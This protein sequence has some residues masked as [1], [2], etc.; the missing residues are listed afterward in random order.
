[1]RRFFLSACVAMGAMALP[2]AAANASQSIKLDARLGQTVMPEGKGGPAYLRVS[3]EGI[4][5]SEDFERTPANVMLVIDRSG[6][7]KG[8]RIEQAKEAAL[9]ALDRLGR[10]DVLGVVAY[11]DEANVLAPAAPLRDIDSVRDRIWG[12]RAGGRTAL[13][14]GVNQGVRQLSEFVD[15]YKVNRVILL[16]DGLANIGPSSPKE[17]ETLG[18]EAAQEGISVTTIGLGLGYN[19][20]LMTRLALA[21]D[22]NHAFVEY[23]EDLIAIFDSE[24]G[25][26][27][28]AVVS[29][30]EIII[31]C[32]DGFEPVRVLGR[33]AKIEDGKVRLKLNQVYG[34]QEKY[35]VV[36]LK[37]SEDRAKGTAQAA[38]VEVNY[39]DL[40]S[41]KRASVKTGAELRF[42]NSKEEI[43][44]SRNDDVVAAVT[45]QIA[46]E[47]S[48]KA[49]E[50]R[51]QG[52]LEEA[53]KLLQDNATYLRRQASELP[54][55][56]ADS[57]NKMSERN[58][59]DA[60]NLNAEA[61]DRTRKSMR[62]DQY[63]R[64]TQQSY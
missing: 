16:S 1:M 7:M 37:V 63:K 5:P 17:L 15:P 21:S 4:P 26:V 14:D 33:E 56:V 19:E 28:A 59:S 47:R 23:P 35:F 58:A 57:L 30:V 34:N 55:G 62:A 24:F 45:T 54:S 61:W 2:P 12:L 60:E 3:L 29:D 27:L 44:A 41:K 64:K 49:V 32:P 8:A 18:R 11:S 22:G 52:E 40:A 31:E 46:T 36:E 13:Y 50:L 42:S 43:S 39:T 9:M 38:N 10:Q 20:D 53:K 6:S 48:E 25:D 51:D